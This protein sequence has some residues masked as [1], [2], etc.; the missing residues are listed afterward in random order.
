[1]IPEEQDRPNDDLETL[2]R[3]IESFLLEGPA[4]LT[5]QE[6]AGRVGVPVDAAARLWRALGFPD[7][8]DD[9]AAFTDT[10]VEVLALAVDLAQRGIVDETS[11]AA[12]TRT[13]G[14]AMSRLAEWQVGFLFSLISQQPATVLGGDRGVL[15]FIEEMVPVLER[16]HTYAWRRHLNSYAS[17]SLAG[18]GADRAE[19]SVVGFVDISGY[20]SLTRKID[21]DE[22]GSLLERFESMAADLVA[23]AGGRI[24]KSLGDEILYTCAD[25]VAATHLALEIVA[26]CNDDPD[27]PDVRAGL[28]YG[29]MMSRLGDVFGSTVNLASR[30]TSIARPSSVLV[31]RTLADVL[32][33]DDRADD[34][35]L[36]PLSRVSVRGFQH[37]QPWLVR[38]LRTR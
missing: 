33:D 34:L 26:R 38:R 35:T 9:T 24:V 13:V 29:A 22:L 28:A 1:M 25:A 37:L 18:R 6:V 3:Q 8:G 2:R 4:H 31:D 11:Q 19:D 32:R 5:R 20:T 15:D 17:R 16:F 14:Q 27:M 36:R 7:V 12:I 21:T 30:L 23:S 10:D